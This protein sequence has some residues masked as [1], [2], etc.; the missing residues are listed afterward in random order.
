MKQVFFL[1]LLFLLACSTREQL[2]SVDIG[3]LPQSEIELQKMIIRQLAGEEDIAL[4]NGEKY[5]LNSR[6]TKEER[7]I[8]IRYF[9]AFLQQLDLPTYKHHYQMPNSNP[10]V[11]LLIEPL[12]GTNVYTILPASTPSTE[13]IIIGGHYDSDGE[14]FPGAIDNGSGVALISSVLRQAQNIENRNKNLLVIYFDQEE[15]NI[16]AGSIAFAKFLKA[17]QYNIHS[18]HCYDLIGWDAD[19]NK[20][21]QLELPSPNIKRL[22]QK[23]ADSLDIPL[24]TTQ[25]ESSDY[26]SFVKEGINAVGMSQAYAKGDVSGKKDSPEDKYHLVNFAYLA[27]STQLAFEVIKELLHE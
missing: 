8:S 13:Y 17:K 7:S 26:Y 23:H 21:V 15:E 12:R 20:E 5:R 3:D 18:V 11:D 27:S 10:A 16:S 4:S 25:A 19:N 6:W 22:Y 1:P 2:P 24:F 14:N 9:E